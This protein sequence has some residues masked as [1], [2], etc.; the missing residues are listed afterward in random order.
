MTSSNKTFKNTK[1]EYNAALTAD[2]FA[3]V[4]H[5][6]AHLWKVPSNAARKFWTPIV[7]PTTAAM[8]D[9][10]GEATKTGLVTMTADDVMH[11]LGV[12]K[13]ELVATGVQRSVVYLGVKPK[14][15]GGSTME[16]SFPSGVYPPGA[17]LRGR[18]GP[19]LSRE[20]AAYLEEVRV[21]LSEARDR[22]AAATSRAE[23]STVDASLG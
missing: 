19:E 9:M 8:M 12:R 15:G 6:T 20:F 3:F 18:F 16:L 14:F 10:I 2:E 22:A 5:D 1:A 4:R 17:E 11:R 23:V 13:R 21:T 7:G